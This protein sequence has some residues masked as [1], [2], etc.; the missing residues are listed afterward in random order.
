M[1]VAGWDFTWLAGR[2]IEERPT[3]RYFDSVVERTG[4]TSTMLDLQTG[5]GSMMESLRHSRNWSSPPRAMHQTCRV[6]SSPASCSRRAPRGRFGRPSGASNCEWTAFELVT[7]RHPIITWWEEMARV[8]RPRGTYFAQHVGPHSLPG[9]ERIPHGPATAELEPD[10]SSLNELLSTPDWSSK[11]SEWRGHERSS[12]TSGQSCTSSASSCG[13]C[14]AS[15]STSTT[16]G[17]SRCTTSSTATA[18]SRQ[19]RAD[20]SSRRRNPSDRAPQRRLGGSAAAQEVVRST[21]SQ[22][23]GV[24]REHAPCSAR[25]RDGGGTRRVSL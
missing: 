20:T 6:G 18:R 22:T 25:R 2:A 4:A 8:L 1:P 12:T 5:S 19:L 14:P 17:S 24:S 9:F 21:M 10:P 11:T 15:P 3:W 23:C 16:A 7:S 13:S